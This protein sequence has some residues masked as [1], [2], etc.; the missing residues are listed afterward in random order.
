MFIRV[1]ISVYFWRIRDWRG[2]RETS[3]I[4]FILYIL[5]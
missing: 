1:R 4:P 3:W 5:A 2:I